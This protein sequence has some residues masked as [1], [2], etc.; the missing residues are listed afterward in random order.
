MI[1]GSGLFDGPDRATTRRATR[2]TESADGLTY[3]FE[4][5]QGIKFHNGFPFTAEDVQFSRP[6]RKQLFSLLIPD[7]YGLGDR[8]SDCVA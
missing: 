7:G 6:Y 4:L 2:W 5:R 8:I 3:D 1:P